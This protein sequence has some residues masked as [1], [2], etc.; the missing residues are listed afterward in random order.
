M[1]SDLIAEQEDVLSLQEFFLATDDV[2]YQTVLSGS[3]YWS[4]LSTPQR[5]LSTLIRLDRA[6]L[7]LRY[8]R[9][10]WWAMRLAELPRILACTLPAITDHP[11]TMFDVLGGLV[12]GFPTQSVA[13]HHLML[14]ELFRGLTGRGNWVERSGGSS[15]NCA[16]LMRAFPGAKVIYLTRDPTANAWSMC[17][18]PYFQLAE[19]RVE[20]EAR[21]GFDPYL[22]ERFDARTVPEDLLPCLPARLTG[23][24][25]SAR[26][27]RVDRFVMLAA[28]LAGVV[29]QAL[30][31]APATVL[32]RLTYE[33]LLAD[34]VGQLEM[35]GRFL[36][37]DDPAE[38]AS[39]VAGRVRPPARTLSTVIT[40]GGPSRFDTIGVR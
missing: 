21:C 35:V 10:G 30:S 6:P 28:F 9:N 37:F 22:D 19:L 34:P 24:L 14:F 15:R 36:E 26:G 39:R 7:E 16:E 5:G 25:L 29:E 20:F 13:S 4:V 32:L 3:E 17:R 11:D 18:H 12:P 40:T 23:D 27:R 38:W 1:L 33:D 2:P 8:P 31:E